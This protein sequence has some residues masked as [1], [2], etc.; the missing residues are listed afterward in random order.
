M[1]KISK[2]AIYTAR[3]H[4]TDYKATGLEGMTEAEAM[5]ALGIAG[6]WWVSG[7]R[8]TADGVAYWNEYFD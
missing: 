5:E 4:G 2:Q 3:Y 6:A 1:E 8:L 7:F